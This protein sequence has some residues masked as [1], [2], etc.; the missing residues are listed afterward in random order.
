MKK[1]VTNFSKTHALIN[2]TKKL[3]TQMNQLMNFFTKTT[4]ITNSFTRITKKSKMNIT[5]ENLN[6]IK[7]I[8]KMKRK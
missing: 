2:T 4:K 1:L 7:L 8:R 3:K 6:V 5:F